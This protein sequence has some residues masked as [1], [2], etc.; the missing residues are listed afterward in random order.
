MIFKG[1]G[2]VLELLT[3]YR[4]GILSLAFF[5]INIYLLIVLYSLFD[6]Y[7]TLP[8]LSQVHFKP[9]Y[10][11]IDQMP[12]TMPPECQTYPMGHYQMA[13]SSIA[14][15]PMQQPPPYQQKITEQSILMPP[16]MPSN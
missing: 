1:I 10:K 7:Q 14:Q 13:G 15:M 4:F 2:L 16:A 6:N 9:D 12:K 5:F 3:S 8:H 11:T